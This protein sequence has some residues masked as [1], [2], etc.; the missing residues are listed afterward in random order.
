M[1]T[2]AVAGPS[3]ARSPISVTPLT[4]AELTSLPVS[5]PAFTR[6]RKTI[7]RLSPGSSLSRRHTRSFPAI[8]GSRL[9]PAKARPGESASVTTTLSS[10]VSSVTFSTVAMKLRTSPTS[11]VGSRIDCSMET[12]GM[13]DLTSASSTRSLDSSKK[14]EAASTANAS[15]LP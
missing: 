2:E 11:A 13:L 7:S 6:A 8:R 5:W 14:I 10:A 12:I 15:C 9:P 3:N 1:R 4:R